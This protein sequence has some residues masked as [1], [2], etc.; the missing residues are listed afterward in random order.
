MP[1]T[2]EN[3]ILSG[4]YPDPCIIRVDDI[5]YLINSSFQFFPGLPIHKSKDLTNR[6]L[7]GEYCRNQAYWKAATNTRVR[8]IR[9]C[10]QP[11]F[12][13]EPSTCYNQG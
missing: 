9:K 7:I 13:A 10:H 3:P 11:A 12:A 2:Y 4:F 8:T 5:F 1:V 6:E